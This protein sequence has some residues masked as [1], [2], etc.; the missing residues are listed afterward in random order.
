MAG[1]VAAGLGIVAGTPSRASSLVPGAGDA[2]GSWLFGPLAGRGP[3]LGPVGL[4]GLLIVMSALYALALALA[5]HLPLR[6]A[7]AGAAGAHAVFAL[8]PPLLSADVFGYVAYARLGALHGRNPYLD[9]AAVIP[10]DPVYAHVT[11]KELASPYGPLFTLVTYV[12]APLGVGGA[13][14]ALK[15]GSAAASLASV[16]LV[17]RL[18][19]WRG[20]SASAAA[21]FVGVNPLLLVWGVG[22]GH[23][24]TVVMLLTIGAIWLAAS[25]RRAGAAAAAVAAVAVKASAGVVLPF[26]LLG[27]RDRRTSAAAAASAA[28]VLVLGLAAFGASGLT[29]HLNVLAEQA[30]FVSAHSVPSELARAIGLPPFR[31]AGRLTLAPAVALAARLSFAVALAFLLLRAARG[32]DWVTAAGWATLALLVSSTFL[33]PWYVVWLL[34]LAAVGRSPALRA[35]TLALTAFVL[36][37][38]LPLPPP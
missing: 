35:A 30:R 29:G 31:D 8:G 9:A 21:I 37:T 12:L 17:A 13:V 33:L 10:G 18:A 15:L 22:G 36:V 24:D 1:V 5:R 3:E 19:A 20:R 25:Y 11:W 23:N 32:A 14:W 38:R 6:G 2:P 26:V 16:A 28:A 4:S 34:P 7:V 27:G